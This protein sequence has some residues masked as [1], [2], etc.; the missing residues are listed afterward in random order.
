MRK[1]ERE[2]ERERESFP[3]VSS[4][5]DKSW[6]REEV[7]M[8][9]AGPLGILLLD[10]KC[11]DSPHASSKRVASYNHT[12]VLLEE[13]G[14]E[15]GSGRKE[16]YPGY[17]KCHTCSTRSLNSLLPSKVA[18]IFVAARYKPCGKGSS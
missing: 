2:R 15:G 14:R 12:I 8:E 6:S 17:C 18:N 10:Q 7:A 1:R 16:E 3:Q 4:L 5:A 11:Q 9:T 13:R